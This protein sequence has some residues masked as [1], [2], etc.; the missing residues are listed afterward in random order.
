MD[1]GIFKLVHFSW[2]VQVTINTIFTLHIYLCKSTTF[3]I[4]M[5]VSVSSDHAGE[6]AEIDR[7]TVTGKM[8]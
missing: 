6:N 5:H 8:F 1:I 7:Q 4:N 2:Y 3:I